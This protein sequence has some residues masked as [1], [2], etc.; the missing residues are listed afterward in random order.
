[1]ESRKDEIYERDRAQKAQVQ[2][3]AEAKRKRALAETKAA[4][5]EREAE[6]VPPSVASS[7]RP[8]LRGGRSRSSSGRQ[9]SASCCKRDR[10]AS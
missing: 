10:R 3:V 1:M 9:R 5:R 2:K 6:R 4:I 7:R 8:S